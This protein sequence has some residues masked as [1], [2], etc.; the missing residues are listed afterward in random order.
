MTTEKNGD[1]DRKVSH[2]S[3][4]FAS[5]ATITLTD[6]DESVGAMFEGKGDTWL[7]T[8]SSKP[9]DELARRRLK[10][11]WQE[12]EFVRIDKIRNCRCEL[13]FDPRLTD[14]RGI[15]FHVDYPASG[16]TV[17]RH[18]RR[19]GKNWVNEFNSPVD[20]ETSPVITEIFAREMQRT[21]KRMVIPKVEIFSD[22]EAGQ[23]DRNR[24]SVFVDS[25]GEEV[26][27]LYFSRA[28]EALHSIGQ[29]AVVRTPE[30]DAAL[31]I[32][33]DVLDQNSNAI[34]LLEP[35]GS[36]GTWD[37]ALADHDPDEEPA[38]ASDALR[39]C[40]ALAESYVVF[41]GHDLGDPETADR[42]NMARQAVEMSK[43]FLGM[44]E[45]DFDEMGPSGPE[46]NFG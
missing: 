29:I 41:Q 14:E 1:V 25:K 28:L 26:W 16:R 40:I 37:V 18:F 13:M 30:Q 36:A 21:L 44:H 11:I 23:L 46:A 17:S 3:N 32:L 15:I 4:G 34:D 42:V 31:G 38:T 39:T 27:G 9:V 5:D 7:N 10:V 33:R 24:S 6:S 45:Y 19:K 12:A 8:L 20:I 35:S 2:L 22:R 43:D